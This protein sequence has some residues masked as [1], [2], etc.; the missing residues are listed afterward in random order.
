MQ[1]LLGAPLSQVVISDPSLDAW[2]SLGLEEWP[3]SLVSIGGGGKI[4][5]AGLVGVD[6]GAIVASWA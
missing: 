3:T 2:K 5:F 6:I 4:L 1:L